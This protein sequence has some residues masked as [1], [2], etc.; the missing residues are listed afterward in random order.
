MGRL[1]LLT[2]AGL[3]AESGIRTFRDSNGL[4]EQ[5]DVATVANIRTWK[6]HRPEMHAF[7]NGRRSQ[8]AAA[9][10]NAAHRKIAEWA[11]R[12]QTTV[13]TQNVDDLLER[14]GCADVLHVHGKLTEM[15]CTACSHV[16]PIGYQEWPL[17]GR[18]ARPRCKSVRG[19]KPNVVFFGEKAPNYR[20]MWQTLEALAPDDVLVVIG[21][22]GGVIRI[23]PLVEKHR[24]R[25]I[26]NNLGPEP[27]INESLYSDVF[28]EPAT[29]A[30]EKID[31]I[32]Q[33]A[34]S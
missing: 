9:E 1:I 13:I 8:V 34:L 5:H 10:P 4:W 24:G 30:V 21:T 31:T 12:Y 26:L 22:S 17:D 15:H 16:W 7:Y 3:S 20:P 33:W 23:D 11:A 18:C 14:A 28:H 19:V 32:L 27:A 6:Q 2:G 25:A 29:Q